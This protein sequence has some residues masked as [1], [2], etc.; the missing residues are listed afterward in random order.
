VYESPLELP[1][2]RLERLFRTNVTA[3]MALVQAVVP[4][5][6]PGGHIVQISS[7]TARHVPSAR[8][9]PYAASKLAVEELTN[10]L[11]WEL[12]PRGIHVSLIAPGLV[13]TPIY[14]KVP[15]F[16]KTRDKIRA[17]VPHWLAPADVADAIIWVLTRPSNVVVSELAI[18]PSQ[19]TR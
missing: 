2:E 10:A 13:D 7:I 19:Q 18:M 12:H 4:R 9:A 16:S 3:A 6:E 14:D 8:F 17:Q 5:M 15:G 11:R 1:S